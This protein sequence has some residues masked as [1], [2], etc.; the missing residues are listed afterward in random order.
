MIA[1][2]ALAISPCLADV[3]LAGVESVRLAFRL[4]V[5]VDEVSQ[6]LEPRDSTGRS[7]SWAHVLT[8]VTK[9][10]VQNELD[11]LYTDEVNSFR[12]AYL[13]HC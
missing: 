12:P 9:D 2:A 13:R 5:L 7:E 10:T 3:P 8:D 1:S 11:K 4:G 6:N